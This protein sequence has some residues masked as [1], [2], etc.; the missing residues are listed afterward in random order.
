MKIINNA[1]SILFVAGMAFLYGC[2]K[3]Q[4]YDTVTPPPQGHFL[5]TG[6]T[7]Y[8]TSDPNSVF[9][10]PVGSTNVTTTGRTINIAVSSPT[11]AASG[12]QYTIT[13]TSL[14]IAAGKAVDTI[15]V[16]GLFAGFTS[17]RV[18]TLVLTITGGDLAPSDASNV[19][20]LVLRKACDVVAANLVG[21]FTRST[22]TYS[23]AASKDPNYTA[24][25]SN[26][27]PVTTT[28]A[29]VIIKNL[30]ATSDNGWGPFAATDPVISTGVTATL[31]YADPAKL[32]VTIAN[33]NYFGSGATISTITG[34]GTFSACDNTYAITC[35]VRYGVNGNSYTHVSLLN[36]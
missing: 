13:S 22:D 19:Y 18:D 24:V 31:N 10:I 14:T 21:S 30:G 9:K 2:D 33:Q 7:Y 27:T 4:Q 35:T 34:T 36:K 6:G 32:T 28:S 15:A 12:A 16:K 17:T 20:K 25:I 5:S 29:T 8:V 1:A 23:G 26:F 3:S 11:G